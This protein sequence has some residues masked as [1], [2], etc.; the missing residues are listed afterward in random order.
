M[1]RL[2]CVG[3]VLASQ[4]L[5]RVHESWLQQ[6]PALW[7][8]VVDL[9]GPSSGGHLGTGAGRPHRVSYLPFRFSAP[10]SF[11]SSSI[12]IFS[13]SPAIVC[14]IALF[15]RSAFF[16]DLKIYSVSNK[17]DNSSESI[18]DTDERPRRLITTTSQSSTTLSI[19]DARFA[20]ASL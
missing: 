20:R 10:N 13:P 3:A 9:V 5:R 6:Y 19:K 4:Y 14:S 11:R 2:A 1:C 7:L 17:L 12:E 18:I 16:G 15:K 8:A